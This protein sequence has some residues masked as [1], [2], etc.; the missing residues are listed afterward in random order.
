MI[1]C[2]QCG[3]EFKFV[4]AS[5]DELGCHTVCPD[6]GGSFDIEPRCSGCDNADCEDKVTDTNY[7]VEKKS[8]V[9]E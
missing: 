1:I 4:S 8:A 3:Y 2:L 6:C 5:V 9:A 7:F